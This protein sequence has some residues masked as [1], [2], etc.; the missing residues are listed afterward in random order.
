MDYTS[1]AP[2]W[3]STFLAVVAYVFYEM[4]ILAIIVNETEPN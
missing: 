2:F 3:Q 1:N 4:T